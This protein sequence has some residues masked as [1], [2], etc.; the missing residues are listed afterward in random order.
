MN[1]ISITQKT[2]LTV[3]FAIFMV[4]NPSEL[5]SQNSIT[6]NSNRGKRNITIN[7]DKTDLSIQYEGEITLS[8]DEKDIKDISRR[9]Y[10]EIKK[11]SFGRKRKIVIENDSG[12]LVRKYYVGW[13]E[14]D[15]Y[16][17]GKE[18]LEEIL[19]EILRSTTIAAKSRVERFYKK[20]GANE[21][22]SE[23]KK[24]ESDYVQSHYFKLLLEKNLNTSEVVS[25][26][27]T[28]G[29]VINS[30]HYLSQILKTN[31]QLFL[32]SPKTI[33][34]YIDAA[35]SINSD[36]YLTQIL[37]STIRDRGISDNQ[38]E[39]L[40]KISETVNSDHYL[41]EI[42]KEIMDN[43]DLNKQN[44]EQVMRLSKTINSDHYKTI[45]LKKALRSKNIS[46]EAYNSFIS[47]L[48]DINSDHYSSEVIKELMK[49][50]LDTENLNKVLNI[51]SKNI[52]SDHY[53]TTIYKK[54]ATRSDL[55]E[56]QIVNILNA[57]KNIGSSHYLSETLLAFAPKVKAGSSKL[58]EAYTKVAKS[59]NS[60]TYF[61]KAMKAIY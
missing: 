55:T 5:F 36:H 22:L 30:D 4:L 32:K 56:D 59:I 57:S 13:S 6:I 19:P 1:T 47:S 10:I 9:G 48:D 43:R 42:L 44:M 24:M 3:V 20:G 45:I 53:A 18:W 28:A 61:G 16:P 27:N 7:N 17:D 33:D 54:M 31:Q 49:N 60:D 46:K 8:D 11:S 39:S 25:T 15:Y 34:A 40:L 21:V 52:S 37:K 41:S 38:L 23:I 2:L 50:E 26:I 35:K 12:K 58:K 29:K 51:I 14:K